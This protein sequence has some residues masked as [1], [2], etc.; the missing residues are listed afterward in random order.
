MESYMEKRRKERLDNYPE[1]D[2]MALLA[3]SAVPL[4][5]VGTPI[6]SFLWYITHKG[7]FTFGLAETSLKD[8]KIGSIVQL[9]AIVVFLVVF[10]SLSGTLN[11]TL[12]R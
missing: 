6:G 7:E 1:K 3:L 9:V 11:V 10:F 4:I 8:A 12:V 2:D 5:G